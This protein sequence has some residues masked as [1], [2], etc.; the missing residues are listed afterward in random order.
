M[1][2][3]SYSGPSVFL[4]PVRSKSLLAV[5]AVTAATAA[6]LSPA[7]ARAADSRLQDTATGTAA[8][9]PVIRAVAV[10]GNTAVSTSVI[11]DAAA[12]SIF[13]KPGDDAAIRAAVLAVI[14]IYRDRNFPVAQVVSTEVSPDGV[15]RLVI[16]EGTVRR[17][18]VRGNSRTRTGIILKVLETKPGS[19][20]R[21]DR[22][23]DDRNRLARLGIFADVI[24]APVV[25]GELDASDPTKPAEDDTSSQNGTAPP[26]EAGKGSGEAGPVGAP[27]TAPLPPSGDRAA[28]AAAPVVPPAPPL[29]TEEDIVGLVDVVVRV[30]E[31][32][33]GNVAA[34]VGYTDGTG[35][36]G[37]LDLTENN[38]G[39]S[40]QRAAVQWQRL[41]LVSFDRFGNQSNDGSRQ[42]FNVSYSQ[43]ALS[44]R[45]LAYGID[46]Y[47]KQTV[48]LPFFS[49]NQDT[50]RNYETRRGGS[51]RIGR[52]VSQNAAVYL[53][54]RH[55]NV[56][57]DDFN[58]IPNDLN[59]PFD[60]L[61]NANATV[62]A[63]GLN[64]VLDGR[65][66]ADNPHSGYLN[67]VVVEQAGS[68]L[69]GNRSFGLARADLRQYFALR[70]GDSPPIVA[71]RLMGGTTYGGNVPLSEYFFLGGF[72]LLRGYNLYSIYGQRMVLGSAELRAP[73]SEAIQGVVFVDSGSAF[74]SGQSFSPKTGV[75]I[76]LRFLTPIGPI[77][78]DVA[79]G[80]RLQTYVSLGQSF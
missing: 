35:L 56:G 77:R 24:V 27:S 36:N 67:S 28:Q 71:L 57:Y 69:G 68:F 66:D 8:S 19:V 73:L 48:F 26:L 4:S 53:S 42:A 14:Q 59:P 6:L 9:A 46:L 74:S 44:R 58:Q 25:P 17:I 13:G 34:T 51:A 37:F 40:A 50:I 80:S 22:A 78:V 38:V 61:N 75:G 18:L 79:Q 31:I 11:S 3:S 29:G 60:L 2:N 65:N 64:L 47:N 5:T 39:G 33:T 16:A 15:L 12:R 55:D 7:T 54:A 72:D 70:S 10:S 41:S 30:K 52:F 62:G 43:P 49:R 32:K 1:N 21:S 20:Y 76:G 63:L 45:S 23:K